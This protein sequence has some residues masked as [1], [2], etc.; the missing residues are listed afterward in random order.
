M[1]SLEK[2]KE[3]TTIPLNTNS[4]ELNQRENTI[5]IQTDNNNLQNENYHQTVTSMTKAEKLEMINKIFLSNASFNKHTK[6]YFLTRFQIILILDKSNILNDYIYLLGKDKQN[7]YLYQ[8]STEKETKIEIESSALRIY[9]TP[10]NEGYCIL[11][12][13][14][15]NELKYSENYK[16]INRTSLYSDNNNNAVKKCTIF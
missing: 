13:N 5:N 9:H 10:F 4:D 3:L 7:G 2:S 16:K 15:L 11:Y 6:E 14:L 1:D 8:I 12:R